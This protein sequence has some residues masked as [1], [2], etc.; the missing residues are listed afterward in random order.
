[1]YKD[2]ENV[3]IIIVLHILTKTIGLKSN[4]L[5]IFFAIVI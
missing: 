4:T 2:S 1:M 3:G 5:I